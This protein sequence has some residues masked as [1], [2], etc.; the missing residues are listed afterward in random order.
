MATARPGTFEYE[1]GMLQYSEKLFGWAKLVES[2]INAMLKYANDPGAMSYEEYVDVDVKSVGCRFTVDQVKDFLKSQDHSVIE[3]SWSL[4]NSCGQLIDPN[5]TSKFIELIFKNQDLTSTSVAQVDNKISDYLVYCLTLYDS[6]KKKSGLAKA[7]LYE[8]Y[9]RNVRVYLEETDLYYNK[10]NDNPLLTGILYDM[11]SEY[12][13]YSSGYKKNLNDFK[14][15]TRQYLPLIEDI[16]EFEWLSPSKDERL[17]FDIEPYE[18]LT[19]VPT[20][21]IIDSTVVL[22]SKLKYLESYH[23]HDPIEAIESKLEAI[24]LSTNPGMSKEKLWITFFLY[25][26]EYR[27]ASTRVNP[28]PSIYRVPERVGD[29][30]VNFSKVE[31]FFDSLQ[32]SSTSVSVRRRFCGAKAHEAFVVFKTFGV[33]FPRIA[34]LNVPQKYSYLNVDYY[35]FAKRRYLSDEEIIILSNIAKDVDSMCVER[36]VSVKNKPI[37]QRKGLL[38]NRNRLRINN[39]HT[40][41]NQLWNNAGRN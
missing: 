27:T 22:N 7:Q 12:N 1:L 24:M 5:D 35:K 30:E 17:L 28:R 9:I 20:L 39:K 15:F 29:W 14:I 32:R 18:I 10:P 26:G 21:S 11:C 36:T 4:S 37:A 33:G 41:V 3:H 2:E 6:S 8:S 13:I 31:E 19:D 38:I 34:R 25:Y 16:F 23:E 40:L